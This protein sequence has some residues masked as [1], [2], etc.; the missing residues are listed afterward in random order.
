VTWADYGLDAEGYKKYFAEP[1]GAVS[2]GVLLAGRGAASSLESFGALS[3][4]RVKAERRMAV[5]MA[6]ETS[7]TAAMTAVG[8]AAT[9]AGSA[10]NAARERLMFWR[11][12]WGYLPANI[13]AGL[14]GFAAIFAFTRLLSPEAMGWYALA[15]AASNVLHTV[16][17]TWNEAA[18][19][20]FE[21]TART[22]Q[23]RANHQVTVY[24]VL[25]IG[26]LAFPIAGLA[27]AFAPV[28]PGL[29]AAMA[30][31]VGS[32]MARSLLQIAQVRLRAVG[33][34][35]RAAGLDLANT[36]GALAFGLLFAWLG[37]QGAAPLAGAAVAAGLCAALGHAAG[38]ARLKGGR[39]EGD[40]ADPLCALRRAAVAV[41]DADPGARFGG[42]GYAGALPR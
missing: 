3:G 36:L 1:V 40:R 27:L 13:V 16:C 7:W 4:W 24:T 2:E 30:A 12:V 29:K 37:L 34:V 42:P 23:E 19:A 28:G 11:G 39:F 22:P 18:L 38:T 8:Q 33:D 17:F 35:K 9:S 41:A 10:P 25:A 15:I 31:G 21:Q 5:I 6:C 20:R 26:W 32:V 14:A